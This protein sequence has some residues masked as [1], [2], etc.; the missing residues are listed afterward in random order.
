M[1]GARVG[2]V[3]FA[4]LLALASEANA[5][6]ISPAVDGKDQLKPGML[7]GLLK[8]NANPEFSIKSVEQMRDGETTTVVQYF[9][10]FPNFRNCFSGYWRNC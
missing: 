3:P 8:L 7:S 9:P 6:Q 5:S 4:F 1:A 2:P 10:N